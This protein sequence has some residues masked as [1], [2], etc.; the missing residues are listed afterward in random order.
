LGVFKDLETRTTAMETQPWLRKTFLEEYKSMK[1]GEYEDWIT[2]IKEFN[3][4]LE[5][6]ESSITDGQSLAH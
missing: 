1:G 3:V 5:V 4:K 6:T 2:N